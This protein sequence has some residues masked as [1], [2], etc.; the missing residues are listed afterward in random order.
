MF[1]NNIIMNL[2]LFFSMLNCYAQNTFTIEGSVI[3]DRGIP[4]SDVNISIL[5]TDRGTIS[6]F[7]GNFTLDLKAGKTTIQF[8]AMGYRTLERVIVPEDYRHRSITVKMMEDA[9][10]LDQVVITGTR[11]RVATK[12]APVVVNSI[13]PKLFDAVNSS[14]MSESLNFTPGVRLETNCQNCNTTQV[15]MNGLGGAYSQLLIN[16]RPIFSALNGVYG[17]EQIPSNMIER[18]EVVRG[19]GSSLYGAGAVGGTINVITKEPVLN[20]WNIDMNIGLLGGQQ[21]DR[22]VSFNASIVDDELNSGIS[23]Y[24]MYRNR[25]GFDYNNDGFTEKAELKDNVLGVD[26]FLNTGN[27]GKLTFN[28]MGINSF[29]RGGDH[30][31]RPPHETAITEQLDHKTVMGGLSYDFSSANAQTDY[32]VYTSGQYTYRKDYYGGLGGDGDFWNADPEDRK[33]A[34]NA[35]GHA[36]NTNLVNGLKVKHQFNEKNKLTLGA[37][38]SYED[39][40]YQVPGYNKVTQQSVR[41]YAGYA[42]YEWNPI[43]RFTT[44]LGVRADRVNV[45]GFYKIQNDERSADVDVTA[46]SPRVSLMYDWTQ[47]FR[48]RWGYARGFRP[49]RAYD[50]DFEVGSADEKQSFILISPQLKSEYSDAFTLSFNYDRIFNK[51]QINFL[52]EGFYT[53]IEHPFTRVETGESDSG[54]LIEEIRN[55]SD[56]AYVAGVNFDI[57]ISPSPHYTFQIGGTLQTAAYKGFQE[58]ND[59]GDSGMPVVGSKNMMRSPDYYGYMNIFTEPVKDFHFDITGT[60]TGPMDVPHILNDENDFMRIKHTRDFLDVGFKLSYELKISDDFRLIP[61]A[62]I[63][64]ILDAYQQDF[65]RGPQ[66]DSDY[67]YGPAS[68]RTYFFGLKMGRF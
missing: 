38:H 19:G 26:A 28:F 6:D 35:Y 27:N 14:T 44:L 3:D 1:K 40:D 55:G 31:K 2:V 52:I 8:K 10:G 37:E 13:K 32:S 17:L 18:I 49:P 7:N 15:R 4:I 16:G 63:H 57:G 64:N 25:D 39:V 30:L 54:S 41:N 24:G 43:K 36:P 11:D 68:P 61:Y 42:Q 34:L 21:P 47:D 67:I 5:G 59:P 20:T 53:Q 66:R 56:D 29:R 62:G 65:D 23:V 12:T 46:L 45:N 60:Y 51:M 50:E 22:K 9:F 48:I 58:L 33:D